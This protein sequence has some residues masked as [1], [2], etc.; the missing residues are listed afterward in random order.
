MPA[1]TLNVVVVSPVGAAAAGAAIKPSASKAPA[2][3]S[4][5]CEYVMVPS[6]FSRLVCDGGAF[7]SRRP[8]SGSRSQARSTDRR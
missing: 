8:P 6:H 1:K 7:R 5:L 3:G 2:T 4:T